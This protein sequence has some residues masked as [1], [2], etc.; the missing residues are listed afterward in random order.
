MKSMDCRS[1]RYLLRHGGAR[2]PHGYGV[3]GRTSAL[4]TLRNGKI[5]I[6]TNNVWIIYRATGNAGVLYGRR[7]AATAA[8]TTK[9]TDGIPRKAG[10]AAAAT[11]VGQLLSSSL[12]L[13]L[14]RDTRPAAFRHAGRRRCNYGNSAARRRGPA[15]VR[16]MYGLPV[17]GR[18]PPCRPAGFVPLG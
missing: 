10:A 14:L 11:V 9:A 7:S 1:P 12:S 6:Y 2:G 17:R 13:S 15:A 18:A 3:R 8:A 5:Y 4:T 16:Q